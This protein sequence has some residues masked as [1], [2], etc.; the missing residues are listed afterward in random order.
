VTTHEDT[1]AEA[2]VVADIAAR[3]AGVQPTPVDPNKDRVAL[4]RETT[5]DDGVRL[6]DTVRVISM[7]RFADAPYRRR[8]LVLF[9]EPDSFSAY[10]NEFKDPAETRIYASLAGRVAVAV[11][12]DDDAT[13]PVTTGAWRDHR[14]ELRV[15]ATPEWERWRKL[16]GRLQSQTD[17]AEHLELNLPDIVE[18]VAADLV[19][20]ARS[21]TASTDVQFRSAVN[22]QSGETRFAYD[23]NTVA[24]ATGSGGSTIDIP[25]IFKLKIAVFQG[26]DP[27]EVAARLRYRLGGGNLSIGYLLDKADD[28]EREAFKAEVGMVGEATG[29]DP[30]YG[31]PSAPITGP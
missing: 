15:R 17:F 9:D 1:N 5:S 6:T 23:E 26:T 12:N 29:L 19:E 30:L 16:D 7:E 25:R 22:L 31:S 10:V 18:P 8:G 14:A 20:I 28:I 11:I 21:F 24:K 27:I 3:A 13:M 4:V 2:A